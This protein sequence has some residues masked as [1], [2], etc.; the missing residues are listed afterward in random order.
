MLSSVTVH[1]AGSS[2]ALF[3]R[4]PCCLRPFVSTKDVQTGGKE[5]D[6]LLGG[7]ACEQ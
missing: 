1:T 4:D 7:I 2:K 3:G 5:S 6:A